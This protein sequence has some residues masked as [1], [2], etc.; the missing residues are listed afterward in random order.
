MTI[1]DINDIFKAINYNC[2]ENGG[3]IY[4]EFE[5]MEFFQKIGMIKS[6][7]DDFVGKYIDKKNHKMILK[8]KK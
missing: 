7:Q 6:N 4:V 3:Y 5:T 2:F 8:F 1:Q